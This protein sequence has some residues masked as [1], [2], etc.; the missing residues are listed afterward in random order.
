MAQPPLPGSVSSCVSSCVSCAFSCALR[1]RGHPPDSTPGLPLQK[2]SLSKMYGRGK[3]SPVPRRVLLFPRN[4]GITIRAPP[5]CFPPVAKY[6]GE[7][8]RSTKETAFMRRANLPY[9]STL[10][11]LRG[12][13]SPRGAPAPP[14]LTHGALQG[15]GAV[16]SRNTF[17]H[18]FSA[19]RKN[20]SQQIAGYFRCVGTMLVRGTLCDKHAPGETRVL[21]T[22]VPDSL[23]PGG[24]S[25]RPAAPQSRSE[26]SAGDSIITRKRDERIYM[27]RTKFGARQ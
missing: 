21:P 10:T 25:A 12:L 19:P 2:E 14:Q 17:R 1:G 9:G 15:K 20:L 7:A 27:F 6:P 26:L 8:R 22:I 24:F 18:T 16:N 4:S 3:K 11:R 23:R 5:F 13:H